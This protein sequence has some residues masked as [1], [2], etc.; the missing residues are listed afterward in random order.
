MF[1]RS[2]AIF[3]AF[4]VGGWLNYIRCTESDKAASNRLCGNAVGYAGSGSFCPN[5]DG[6]VLLGQK[7]GNTRL[8][9]TGA[10]WLLCKK[11]RF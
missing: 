4:V 3:P 2:A 1:G 6:K 9:Q 8:L 5:I 10:S 11:F 7:T